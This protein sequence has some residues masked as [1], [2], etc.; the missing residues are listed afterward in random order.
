MGII[1]I[2]NTKGIEFIATGTING[3][4]I[5][6]ARNSIYTQQTE[7]NFKYLLFDN[8]H[9]TEYNI[10]ANDI[11]DIADLDINASKIYP[12]LI[13]AT[14]ESE[15]LLFSLTEVW[16]AHIEE[17]ISNIK[18]FSDRHSAINWINTQLE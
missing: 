15:Y 13:M 9:C 6:H 14:I 7:L 11:I 12:S 4:E 5:I 17:H 10:T 1:L 16:H 8:S 18:S 2:C 3:S